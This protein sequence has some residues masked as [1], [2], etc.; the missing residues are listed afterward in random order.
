MA[1]VSD[2]D[3][4]MSFYKTEWDQNHILANDKEFFCYQHLVG[5][6][7]NFMLA[8]NKETNSIEGAE[9]FIQYSRELKDIAA[10][11]WKTRSKAAMPFLGVEIIK[12]LKAATEC[13]VYLGCGTNPKTA[14]PL[15]RN[16]LKH[17]VGKLKHFY[18]LADINNYKIA[19]IKENRKTDNASFD[20]QNKLVEIDCITELENK[21]YFEQ[22]S[23]RKPYKDKWYI[24]N[25]YFNHPLYKYLIWAVQADNN[26]FSGLLVAREI[27]VN[28]AKVLRIMDYLGDINAFSGLGF[29]M[30]SLIKQNKYEYID[31]YC[32]GLNE[33]ILNK[34]GFVYK[35]ETDEN[36]IPNYFEPFVQENI[37]IWYTLSDENTLLFKSD[38]DQDRPNQN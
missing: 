30:K 10:V 22:D 21:Y 24:K 8:I 7:V 28:S 5:N 11:M 27:E 13:R 36:I 26:H 38:G 25:R 31:I 14:V 3:A 33:Q 9:G 20:R 23:L 19:I 37:D 12:R 35:T 34:A 32:K 6:R 18:Q 29:E 4:I 16:M 2:I 15:Q 17:K 1:K